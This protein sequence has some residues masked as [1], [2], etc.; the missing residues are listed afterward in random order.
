MSFDLILAL[1]LLNPSA[2]SRLT[3]RNGEM[4]MDSGWTGAAHQKLLKGC[5]ARFQQF[6]SMLQTLMKRPLWKSEV[7]HGR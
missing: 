4:L 3:E 7:K 1:K 2:D 5:S 6:R